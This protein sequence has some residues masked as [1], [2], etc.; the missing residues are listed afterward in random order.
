MTSVIIEEQGIAYTHTGPTHLLAMAP[1][2]VLLH[3]AGGDRYHWPPRLRRLAETQ[4]YALDLPGH[5]H[6]DGA[7]RRTI[8]AY[9]QTLK[10]F[11]E[12]LALPPFILMGHS[13]GGAIAL[14]FALRH[15]DALTGLV[16]VGT[17]SR[18]RVNGTILEG[19]RNAF[20]AT[21]A[22]LIDWMYT[23]T[24]PYRQRALAQ[25]RANNPQTL[26]DD[27]AACDLFDVRQQVTSLSLP[28]LIICGVA[29]KMT[30][31]KWS[32]AL[33][34]A[35]VG[36]RLQI[37]E[38]AGHMVMIEQPEA[39]TALVRAFVTKNDEHIKNL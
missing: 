22:Q 30:P 35:I 37:V 29:D 34:Q 15:P 28:T 19:L 18:L 2:L 31:R 39:V 4:V 33:H 26:Y 17:G 13:M 11:V 6:S 20:E 16:L 12:A 36:S 24:F 38:G 3:G 32:E 21:T 7:G 14:E 1:P 10:A 25:L 5:G 8:A 23:P 9:V 27:F